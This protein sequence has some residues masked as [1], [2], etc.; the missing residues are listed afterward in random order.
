[1]TCLTRPCDNADSG[2]NSSGLSAKMLFR[3]LFLA[4]LGEASGA[5]AGERKLC[6]FSFRGDLSLDASKQSAT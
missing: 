1:M 6:K 3:G 2:D 4:W 5:F